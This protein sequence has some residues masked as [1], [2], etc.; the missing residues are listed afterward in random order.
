[1]KL[2]V[3][4]K[5]STKINKKINLKEKAMEYMQK[6][7]CLK[8]V[9]G[10]T[11]EKFLNI[12][13]FIDKNQSGTKKKIKKNNEE[14]KEIIYNENEIFKGDYLEKNGFYSKIERFENYVR[15]CEG[16]NKSDENSNF[17][18]F[19]NED[20]AISFA[21]KFLSEQICKGFK[22]NTKK[23]VLSLNNDEV[24]TIKAGILNPKNESKKSK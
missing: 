17:K 1:M 9:K 16:S 7:I 5:K 19:S 24:N 18:Q 20:L 2:R 22:R 14:S 23:F 6:E 8:R 11:D 10:F 15:I 13:N 21:K 4:N 12:E 3:L